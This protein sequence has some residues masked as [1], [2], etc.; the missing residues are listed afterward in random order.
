MASIAEGPTVSADM[1]DALRGMTIKVKVKGKRRARI[2]LWLA[3]M[4]AGLAAAILGGDVDL[5]FEDTR[6]APLQFTSDGF[7]M[8]LSVVEGFK[9]YHPDATTIGMDLIIRLDGVEQPYA[10]AYDVEAGRVSR[11]PSDE[12]GK[13]NLSRLGEDDL[14]GLA[15]EHRRG[16]ITLERRTAQV[17]RA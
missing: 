2:R 6:S 12:A 3:C 14:E 7:P 15:I 4:L 17:A 8:A 9:G 10:V 11:Y 13:L 16:V 5:E 1:Q